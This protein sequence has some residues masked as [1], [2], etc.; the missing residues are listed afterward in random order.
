MYLFVFNDRIQINILCTKKIFKFILCVEFRDHMF[1]KVLLILTIFS[2]NDKYN[3]NLNIIFCFYTQSNLQIPS[4]FVALCACALLPF[5][6][7]H[8]VGRMRERCAC[9]IAH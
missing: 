2:E 3:G 4:I 7:Q 5:S 9:L 1:S 8:T 6:N